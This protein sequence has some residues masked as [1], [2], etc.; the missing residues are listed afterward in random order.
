MCIFT[1]LHVASGYFINVL[2]DNNARLVLV[3][4]LQ[5]SLASHRQITGL[6]TPVQPQSVLVIHHIALLMYSRKKK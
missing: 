5:G 2:K 3:I 4:M 1:K 6:R